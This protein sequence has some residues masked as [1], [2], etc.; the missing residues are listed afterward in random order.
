MGSGG[1]YYRAPETPAMSHSAPEPAKRAI[2]AAVPDPGAVGTMGEPPSLDGVATTSLPA[3]PYRSLEQYM[4]LE[5]YGGSPEDLDNIPPSIR[6]Y[7][8]VA[9]IHAE[10]AAQGTGWSSMRGGKVLRLREPESGSL[11]VLKIAISN[12]EFEV[13]SK[14]AETE[15]Q[16]RS[17]NLMYGEW[18]HKAPA[19]SGMEMERDYILMKYHRGDLLERLLENKPVPFRQACEWGAQICSALETLHSNRIIHRD[20]KPD[21]VL[22]H[23]ESGHAVVF[24][25]DS[26]VILK[27]SVQGV[28]GTCFGSENFHPPEYIVG[29]ELITQAYDIWCAGVV[30]WLMVFSNAWPITEH[31]MRRGRMY[32]LRWPDESQRPQYSAIRALLRAMLARAP[33]DRPTAAQCQRSLLSIIERMWGDG[34]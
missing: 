27:P 13:Y 26:S 3:P 25:Y 33:G 8:F 22:L 24:D 12:G 30:I 34:R 29:N 15:V 1:V 4:S 20:I 16:R 31:Q 21:N 28:L 14:L 23:N 10:F 5:E 18:M 32:S 2:M 9:D 17:E 7:E 11:Y 6:R 19:C